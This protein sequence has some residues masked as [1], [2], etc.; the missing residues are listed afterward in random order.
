LLL[1][2]CAA[3]LAIGGCVVAY[4]VGAYHDG[5]PAWTPPAGKAEGSIGYH[6][7]FWP[8]GG[9]SSWYLTPGVRSGLLQP[10]L[11]GDIGLTSVV[12]ERGGEFVALL[13]PVLGIGY[14]RSNF[15]F[16]VRSSAHMLGFFGGGVGFPLWGQVS[17]LAGN[18]AQ[19][20]RTHV[21]GGG[22]IGRLGMGPV[23]LVD[24]SFG[25]VNLRL[26]GSYMFPNGRSRGLVY[27]ATDE[28]L[29]VGLTVGG[30]APQSED[31]WSSEGY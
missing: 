2:A 10:P 13:G 31:E 12:M 18:S 4:H 17:L 11:A 22:R 14:Q 27:T 29:T 16:V 9:G 7:L 28:Q 21:S 30:S 8:D 25:S 6:R 24:H 20:G 3:L 5:L 15:C 19:T 23:L 26:E 1:F